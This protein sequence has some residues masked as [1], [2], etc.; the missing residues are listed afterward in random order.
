MKKVRFQFSITPN[1]VLS[2]SSF[3]VYD[4]E[5]NFPIDGSAESEEKIKQMLFQKFEEK[6]YK[7]TSQDHKLPVS[8]Y[9][10]LGW[11]IFETEKITSPSWKDMDRR[12]APYEQKCGGQGPQ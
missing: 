6:Y 12:Y 1:G 10:I 7:G 8:G 2:V 11:S 9:Q 4:L 5:I 3:Y